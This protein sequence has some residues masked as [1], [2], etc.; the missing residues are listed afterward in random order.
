M[1][2][3]WRRLGAA[4][5]ILCGLAAGSALLSPAA[6]HAATTSAGGY[7]G[8]RLLNL[9]ESRTGDW[10][11]YGTDG[12]TTFD[13]SGLVY[14]AATAAGESNWPR[15]TY[16]IASEIGTRFT[17][18]TDPQRGDLA[19]WGPVSA[20]YHVEFVTVWGPDTTFGALDTGTQVGWHDDSWSA[21]SFYLHIN[22]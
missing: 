8:D 10:Y 20:P 17:I 12:P 18:T 2:R 14:W 6:A 13:C 1:L 3:T 21:P 5:L 9:A 16:E 11:V 22:W 19:L 7:V 15:D 4:F